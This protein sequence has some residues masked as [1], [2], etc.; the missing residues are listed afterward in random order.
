MDF[1]GYNVGGAGVP[2]STT[3]PTITGVTPNPFDYETLS[4]PNASITRLGQSLGD[5]INSVLGWGSAAAGQA[6][7]IKNKIFA[8]EGKTVPTATQKATAL[9][10]SLAGNLSAQTK[11]LLVI[12]GIIAAAVGVLYF[13]RK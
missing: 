10:N 13:A 8:L 4:D 12:G 5:S 11:N 9:N 2:S 1:Y 6:L 7:D 3:P